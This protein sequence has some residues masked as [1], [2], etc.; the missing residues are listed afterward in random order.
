MPISFSA[1][2]TCAELETGSNSV[3]PCTTERMMRCKK[4]MLNVKSRAHFEQRD[5][6]P[7]GISRTIESKALGRQRTRWKTMATTQAGLLLAF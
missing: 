6:E 3:K 7:N 2:T 5:G 1:T 4:D